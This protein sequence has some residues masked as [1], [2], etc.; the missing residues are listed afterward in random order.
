VEQF[1]PGE[2]DYFLFSSPERSLA[3]V[4]EIQ[5][6][7]PPGRFTP[8]PND[9]KYLAN[10]R[11]I[12]TEGGKLRLMAIGDSIVNDTMRSG[13]VSL[14]QAA[15]PLAEITAT[16]YVRGGGGAQHFRENDRLARQVFPRRPDL[17]FLGG[18]SQRSIADLAALIEATPRRTARGR[19]P[20]RHRRLRHDRPARCRPLSPTPRTRAPAIMVD[21]SE[22]SRMNSAAPFSISPRP[23]PST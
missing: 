2:P 3:Q 7:M 17:V 21:V 22:N 4:K 15:Y 6:A 9:W 12:L 8:P 23:G 5:A 16:V 1:D 19:D 11:R 20:A 13:W 18:I 14:L 10:T